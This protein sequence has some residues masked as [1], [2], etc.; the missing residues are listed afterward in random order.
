MKKKS[1]SL[2]ANMLYNSLGSL[3]YLGC[4]WLVSVLVV[5]LAGYE[6]EGLLMLAISLTNMLFSV[7]TFGIRTYQV[8]DLENKFS[9]TVYVTTR[10]LTGAGALLLCV[11]YCLVTPGYTAREQAC[12]VLYMVFKL[13]ES[14]VDVLQGIQQRAYRMDY[15][16]RSFVLRGILS[17]AGFCLTLYLTQDVLWAIVV[18]AALTLGVVWGIDVPTS[19]RQE[20][21][22]FR[23]QLRKSYELLRISWP[24]MLTSFLSN[25]V[26]SIP[27]AVLESQMGSE[28]LGIYGAV[29]TPA[30]LVQTL[31][32]LIYNPLISPISEAYL[33]R[34]QRAYWRLLLRSAGAVIAAATALMLGAALLGRWGLNLLFGPEILPYAYLLLPVLAAT[35]LMAINWYLNM[36]LTIAR[37]L[38]TVMFANLAAVAGVAMVSAP[39]IQAQ[40]MAGVNNAMYVG[41]GLSIVVMLAG[42]ADAWRKQ[43]AS[44]SKEDL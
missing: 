43:F 3:F 18:M 9:S 14:Q 10:L 37:R 16:F 2:S 27:R 36:L 19:R 41:L 29:A 21:F 17:L 34:N 13:S 30:V 42:L 24:L 26:V 5:R 38:K 8:S 25:A 4:Q 15:I 31:C 11:L 6:A 22:V 7:S 28:A 32:L 44:S 12:I 40:G 39:A 20:S 23:P 33:Q 1:L 35:S